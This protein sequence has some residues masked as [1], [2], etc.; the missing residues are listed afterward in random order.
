MQPI[1]VVV[2]GAS[3]KMGREVLAALCQEP[4]MEP[5]GAVERRMGEDYLSLPDGS[6]LIPLSTD[7]ESIIQRTRPQ[8]MVDFSHAE[9]TMPAVRICARNGVAVVVGTTGL[10]QE[11]LEEIGELC[12]RHQIGVVVAPNFAV[13]A[14]IMVYLAR[15]A[16]RYFDYAEIVEMHHE[17]KLDAPSGTALFTAQEMA[18]SRGSAFQ[19]ASVQKETIPSTR[20]GLKEGIPIHSLRLPGLLAHQEVVFGTRG[21][22]LRIRHD[23]LSRECFVPGIMLAI[24]EVVKRKELITSLDALLGL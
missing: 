3:G 15:I 17:Q 19:W 21:Q 11:N 7:L 22:T 9:A 2:H 12:R 6:G 18:R 16:A 20:G 1:K 23:A 14:V 8:V 5:V 24:K 13:G 10:A 4:E